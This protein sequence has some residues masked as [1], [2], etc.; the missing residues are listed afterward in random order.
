[1][2]RPGQL[3]LALFEYNTNELGHPARALSLPD[4]ELAIVSLAAE[5]GAA[6]SGGSL[7]HQEAELLRSSR[8]LSGPVGVSLRQTKREI[9]NGNDPLGDLLTQIRTNGQRRTKGIFLTP[10]EIVGPMVAWIHS[11][12]PA[13]VIDAGAGSGRFAAELVR[14]R[15]KTP[16]LAIEEDAFM[17]LLCRAHLAQVG[18]EAEV[19]NIDYTRRLQLPER[20][21]G[22]TAF[23]GNPPYVRHHDLG[24]ILK[25]WAATESLRLGHRCSLLAGFH[26]YFFLATYLHASEGDWGCFVTSAEWLDVNYGEFLRWLLLEKL[27]VEA[28]H[29]LEHSQVSFDA[30][31][32][33]LVSCFRKGAPSQ[34]VRVRQVKKMGSFGNLSNG[35]RTVKVTEFHG[36]RWGQLFKGTHER[37]SHP[38]AHGSLVRISEIARVHRGVATGANEY[39]VMTPSD[40][41]RLGIR[42]FTVPA[43]SRAKEITVSEGVVEQVARE[44]LVVPPD[45]ERADMP[46]ALVSYIELGEERGFNRRYLCNHRNPWWSLGAPKRPPIVMTYMGRRPPMFAR[47]PDRFVP[48]NIAHGIYLHDEW[49]DD[50][51]RALVAYL[52]RW[53]ARFRGAGRTYHGGLEKFEPKEVEALRIPSRESILALPD[54]NGK[55]CEVTEST[56]SLF[57]LMRS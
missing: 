28:L 15:P 29:L 56:D 24:P 4:G 55:K 47:N 51:L 46:A 13:L 45:M 42:E 11:K 41:E 6:K 33:A 32:T 50:E 48:L 5:L 43:I 26:V 49:S 37:A 36:N 23:I 31:T 19:R 16:V 53:R 12:E 10:Q 34:H 35:G 2:R 21:R 44:V 25:E 52:N 38:A 22:N 18:G 3:A 27:G 40:A 54:D 39:F 17:S 30:M 8:G 7:S 20:V 57:G 9:Q 1:M 14:Q